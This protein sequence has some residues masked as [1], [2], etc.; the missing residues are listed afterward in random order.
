K[1]LHYSWQIELNSF[2][3]PVE[4]E[5]CLW[6]GHI[7]IV[8]WQP[9]QVEIAKQLFSQLHTHG[10]FH[11]LCPFQAYAE[12]YPCEIE[13]RRLGGLKIT[14]ALVPLLSEHRIILDLFDWHLAGCVDS[15]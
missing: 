15:L 13:P 5:C 7:A 6:L 9:T 1:E 10:L 4:V 14:R 8:M 2:T 12:A 3:Q 11:G